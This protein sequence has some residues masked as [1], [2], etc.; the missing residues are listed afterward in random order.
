ML[1]WSHK[2]ALKSCMSDRE[3]ELSSFT[4]ELPPETHRTHVCLTRP[5]SL[6]QFQVLTQ[7]G[8]HCDPEPGGLRADACWDEAAG[9]GGGADLS[10]VGGNVEIQKSEL[11]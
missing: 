6:V 8:I 1:L 3:Q 2:G 11:K 7:L 4:P 5:P 9:D 10:D